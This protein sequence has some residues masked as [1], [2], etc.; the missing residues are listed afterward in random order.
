MT[1]E[2]KDIIVEMLKNNG[3]Y[4]GDPQMAMIYSYQGLG[5]EPLYAVFA[6]EAHDDMEVS[7][8]VR[9]YKLLWS[10]TSGITKDGKEFLH[11]QEST[12]N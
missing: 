2:S 1:Y 9:G 5:N 12:V 4:P 6:H 10:R 11:A 7:P 8:Y 3:V